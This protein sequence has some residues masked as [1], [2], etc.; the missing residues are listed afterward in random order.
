MEN[1]NLEHTT[2]HITERSLPQP[3]PAEPAVPAALLNVRCPECIKL[4]V[5][6]RAEI[7]STE[8]LFEC[9]AC[10]TQF[11]IEKLFL[12]APSV[13]SVIFG[14]LIS[15]PT[16]EQLAEQ[17]A[18]QLEEPAEDLMICAKCQKP[19][20]RQRKECL[21]CGVVFAKVDALKKANEPL[22]IKFSEDKK[23]IIEDSVPV[24]PSLI[25]SYQ[26]LLKD[27]QNITKHLAFVDQ[28]EEL[29]ALPFALKKYKQLKRHQPRDPIAE[30]M[31]SSILFRSF[32]KIGQRMPIKRMTRLAPYVIS[33]TLILLG[34]V[35]E[36]SKNLVGFGAA[37]LFLALGLHWYLHGTVRLQDLWKDG[38]I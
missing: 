24:T 28:C 16:E 18:E 23:E 6:N 22:R 19:N 17:L 3:R 36:N 4:Y 11:S 32:G 7:H 20:P 26:E 1:R 25:R 31:I 29:H 10:K 34:F 5:I 27:Y 21:R 12:T 14:K 2:D 35:V 13:P 9:V 33:M 37:I 15:L 38:D 30:K 8:P